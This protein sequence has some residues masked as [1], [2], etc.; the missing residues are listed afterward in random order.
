MRKYLFFFFIL[1]PLWAFAWSDTDKICTDDTKW[2]KI[3]DTI[4]VSYPGESVDIHNMYKYF[5]TT[6]RNNSYNPAWD[7]KLYYAVNIKNKN[8]TANSRSELYE[9]NCTTKTPKL[10]LNLKI[11]GNGESYY[12]IDYENN[13]NI[14]IAQKFFWIAEW[15]TERIV[16]YNVYSKKKL[17]DL[18]WWSKEWAIDGFVD[19]KSSWYLYFSSEDYD[20]IGKIYQINKNS[21]KFTKLN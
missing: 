17:F 11:Y 2:W 18:N 15:W 16:A 1:L 5:Y 6:D 13:W 8:G 20:H 12:S 9:Y 10:L 14:L 7:K 4:Q 19:S 21:K 3:Y